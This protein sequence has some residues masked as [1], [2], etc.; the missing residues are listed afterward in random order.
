[1]SFEF[2]N[3]RCWF[4]VSNLAR[5]IR[6]HWRYC[7]A[8]DVTQHTINPFSAPVLGNKTEVFVFLNGACNSGYGQYVPSVEG[9]RFARVIH[10]SLPIS[11]LP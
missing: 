9:N 6:Q 10:N 3:N 8:I 1:M 5:L 4:I 7:V 11:Y 2:E